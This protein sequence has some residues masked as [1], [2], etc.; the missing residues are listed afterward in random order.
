MYF[1]KNNRLKPVIF[2]TARFQW[3]LSVK[4][5]TWTERAR[6]C[7]GY[8]T[9]FDSGPAQSMGAYWRERPRPSLVTIGGAGCSRSPRSRRQAQGA[10]SRWALRIPRPGHRGGLP[11]GR[12]GRHLRAE[13]ATTTFCGPICILFWLRVFPCWR[14]P[15]VPASSSS[16][17]VGTWNRFSDNS[18]PTPRGG[19]DG[20]SH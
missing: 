19:L 2:K 16:R 18:G 17:S 1:G 13:C 11:Y 6:V 7:G 3:C 14:L 12:G 15:M 8:K 10:P 9:T 20:R 5:P 4:V